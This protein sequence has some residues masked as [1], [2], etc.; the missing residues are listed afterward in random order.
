MESQKIETEPIG[1]EF[2]AQLGNELVTLKVQVAEKDNY[3]CAG[4]VCENYKIRCRL[5]PEC[6]AHRRSDKQ[7]VIFKKL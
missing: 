2:S 1:R 5:M 3:G 6:K 7:N 4:C